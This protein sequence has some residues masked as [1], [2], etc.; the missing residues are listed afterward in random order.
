[1]QSAFGQ[2]AKAKENTK[3]DVYNRI[4]GETGS[5]VPILTTF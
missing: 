5:F 4:E 2:Y 1:M 3:A